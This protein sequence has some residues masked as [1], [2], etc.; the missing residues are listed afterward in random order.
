MSQNVSP[1]VMARVESAT[2]E[3]SEIPVI[4]TLARVLTPPSS[5]RRG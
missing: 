1:E 5:S 3:S 2:E 4:D